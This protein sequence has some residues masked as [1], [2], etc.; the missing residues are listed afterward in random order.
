MPEVSGNK[1]NV[2]N[3]TYGLGAGK[4]RESAGKGMTVNAD[5]MKRRSYGRNPN[6]FTGEKKKGQVFCYR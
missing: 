6:H 2:K 5:K 1:A 3:F 4:A